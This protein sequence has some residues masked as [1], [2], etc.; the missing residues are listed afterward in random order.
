MRAIRFFGVLT[1]TALL[2]AG[3][4]L[5]AGARNQGNMGSFGPASPKLEKTFPPIP[6]VY[7]NQTTQGH[8]FSSFSMVACRAATHCDAVEATF[9]LDLDNAPGT[10]AVGLSLSYPN[11]STNDVDL[12]A[13]A[14]DS[15]SPGAPLTEPPCRNPADPDCHFVHPEKF[16]LK[17]PDPGTFWL[18]VINDKGVNLGYTIAFEYFEGELDLP[19]LPEGYRPAGQGAGSGGG[20]GGAGANGDTAPRSAF[21]PARAPSF[22]TEEPVKKETAPEV[23]VPGA[24]GELTDHELALLAAQSE[25]RRRGM[26]PLVPIA[27]GIVLLALG[28]FAFFYLRRR[29]AAAEQQTL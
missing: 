19:P 25:E 16:L 11:P 28:A 24:D 26:S 18:T 22:E 5:P 1:A 20:G 7:P 23:K 6:G 9:D 27:I 10:W 4:Y 21:R 2:V 13:W 17:E 29:R 12:F 15:D 8:L 14:N 3:Q